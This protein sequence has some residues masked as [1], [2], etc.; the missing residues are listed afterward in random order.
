[1]PPEMHDWIPIE[2][3]NVQLGA[4]VPSLTIKAFHIHMIVSDHYWFRALRD[5]AKGEALNVPLGEE[6]TE[7]LYNIDFTSESLKMHEENVKIILGYSAEKLGQTIKYAN[8]ERTGM[9]FLWNAYAH[10]A[11]HL[12]H[13]DIYFGAVLD[14]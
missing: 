8:V 5:G 6:L 7:K 13:M 2:N 4:R 12:G 1:M 11:H 9:E 10:R 3:H 14:N